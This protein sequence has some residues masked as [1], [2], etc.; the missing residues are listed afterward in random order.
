MAFKL[1]AY[2]RDSWTT[3]N[4][5][6]MSRN[7]QIAAAVSVYN[8]AID[9]SDASPASVA[10]RKTLAAMVSPTWQACQTCFP[11][12]GPQFYN[13]ATR[14]DAVGAAGA[15]VY[16]G[17]VRAFQPFFGLPSDPSELVTSE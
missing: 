16:S 9:A 12:R 15:A 1:D 8:K 3:A 6:N 17:A 13:S 14:A 10:L 5:R 2:N 11:P 7:A 4:P